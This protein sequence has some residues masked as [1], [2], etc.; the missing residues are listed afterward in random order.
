LGQVEAIGPDGEGALVGGD[1]ADGQRAEQERRHL[2]RPAYLP[3]FECR[4]V[5]LAALARPGVPIPQPQHLLARYSTWRSRV[6]LSITAQRV[7]GLLA[8]AA[9]LH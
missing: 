5:N 7:Q 2:P 9:G 1:A 8:V 6:Q 4:V 3:S